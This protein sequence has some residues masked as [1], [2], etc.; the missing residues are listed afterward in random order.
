MVIRRRRRAV[1]ADLT[2]Q[3]PPGAVRVLETWPDGADPDDRPARVEWLD[4]A[5]TVIP[6]RSRRRQV[7]VVDLP[8]DRQA[9]APPGAVTAVERYQAHAT[10]PWPDDPASTTWLDADGEVVV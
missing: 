3:A 8:A 9:T 6:L 10:E 2:A 4:A 5:D 1:P 7:A